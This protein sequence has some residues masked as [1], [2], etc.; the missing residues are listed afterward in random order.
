M[1]NQLLGYLNA[2]VRGENAELH[3]DTTFHFSWVEVAVIS[4]I[5]GYTV[6]LICR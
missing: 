5:I 1:I 6:Y 2:W 4:G 3:I